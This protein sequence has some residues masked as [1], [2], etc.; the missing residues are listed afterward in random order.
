MHI[1]NSN[2]LLGDSQTRIPNPTRKSPKTGNTQKIEKCAK[3]PLRYYV[4]F[5]RTRSLEFTLKY[6]GNPS[7]GRY[8]YI[9]PEY[10]GAAD[11]NNDTAYTANLNSVIR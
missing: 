5:P 8:L 11:V 1:V 7:F 9:T 4:I 6:A 3:F 10:Y 2:S